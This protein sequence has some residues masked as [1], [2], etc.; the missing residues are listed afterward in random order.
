MYKSLLELQETR[1]PENIIKQG[2]LRAE[3]LKL[4]GNVHVALK[5]FSKAQELFREA[6]D[7]YKEHLGSES[8]LVK[9]LEHRIDEVG[10]YSV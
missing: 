3:A 4:I 5:D 8:N 7:V 1:H 10:I 2:C 6:K 9:D